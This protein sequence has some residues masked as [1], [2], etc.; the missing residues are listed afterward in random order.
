MMR[1][2]IGAAAAALLVVTGVAPAALGSAAAGQSSTTLALSTPQSAYGQIVT[3]TAA[4]SSVPGPPEGDVVF[5]VDG[6]E[7]KANLGASGTAA[8][9]L[10]TLPV[11]DHAVSATFVPQFPQ[12]QQGSSSPT[13]T[14]TVVRVR[15]RL[16]VRVI[17]KGVRIPTSVQVKAAGEYGSLP[18]G[19]VRLVLHRIGSTGSERA[20][21]RLSSS[22]VAVAD[23]GR[24]PKG[25]Y[26]LVV[27]Y[28]GDSQHLVERQFTRFRVQQ[29]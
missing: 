13:Q 8:A 24:L 2:S 6:V 19:R 28:S 26:R 7:I 9:V 14:W 3:A 17:G 20:R 12:A 27:T 21:R 10:P 4:V 15:T 11:G 16:Q 18:T 25:R 22:G 1:R 29:R 5:S 23:F